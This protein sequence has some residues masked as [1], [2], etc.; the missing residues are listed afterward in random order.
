MVR[1]RV[2]IVRSWE[3]ASIWSCR[4]GAVGVRVWV[5]VMVRVK[6]RVEV[7]VKLKTMLKVQGGD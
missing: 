1:V 3:V 2:F 7:R 4:G 5:G 6:V